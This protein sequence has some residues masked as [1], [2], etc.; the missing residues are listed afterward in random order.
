MQKNYSIMIAVPCAYGTEHPDVRT[1]NVMAVM[2]LMKDPRFNVLGNGSIRM[3]TDS[4][5]RIHCA[6][7]SAAREAL[8]AGCDFLLFVDPDMRPDAR[9]FDPF[10][11]KEGQENAA[12]WA[13]PFLSSSLD[14]MLSNYCAIIGAPAVSCSP[15]NKITVFLK[16]DQAGNFSRMSMEEYEDTEPCF[17]QCTAIGT[18][19]MLIDCN[20]F[21]NMPMPWFEDFYEPDKQ[22]EEGN[23]IRDPQFNVY[24][25]QDTRFCIKAVEMG[26]RVYA[27][28]F[29]PAGHIKSEM[30]L[31]PLCKAPGE[32]DGQ[33]P[34]TSEGEHP[35]S[36]S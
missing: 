11:P 16:R 34:K 15:K 14:F 27:N 10:L 8:E 13:L 30:L 19:M 33:G 32:P 22:D 2:A 17:Q 21:K 12:D 9:L 35:R 31:P 26:M 20:V 28:H 25:S 4:A 7:N 5:H 6:R 29:A 36:G 3:Y 24:Q 1:W 23:V 18:G